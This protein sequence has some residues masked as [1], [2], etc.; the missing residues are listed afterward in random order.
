MFIL[1]CNLQNVDC[2]AYFN[3]FILMFV[4]TLFKLILILKITK[5]ENQ[6]I[7]KINKQSTLIIQEFVYS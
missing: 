6:Q 2:L 3:F 1:L 4:I 7:G 5:I